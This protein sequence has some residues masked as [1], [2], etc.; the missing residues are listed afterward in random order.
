MEFDGAQREG[1]D[2]AALVEEHLSGLAG[3]AEN[4]VAPG[5][6]VAGRDALLYPHYGGGEGIRNRGLDSR[7]RSPPKGSLPP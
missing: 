5:A 7:S 2:K 4:D 6:V 3:E 1:G